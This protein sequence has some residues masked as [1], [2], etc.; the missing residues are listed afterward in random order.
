MAVVVENTL[1]K[2]SKNCVAKPPAKKYL[3]EHAHLSKASSGDIEEKRTECKPALM[4][5]LSPTHV[6]ARYCAP[7]RTVQTVVSF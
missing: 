4:S 5:C 6:R 1:Y 3:S 2:G 7:L